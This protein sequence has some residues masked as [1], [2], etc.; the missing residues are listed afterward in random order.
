[1]R[2]TFDI[3]VKD[4][5][6]WVR[7]PSAM[8]ILLGMPAIL[9]LILGFALGGLTSGG[10]ARIPVAIVNLDSRPVALRADSA[11][12]LEDRL[13]GEKRI[14][15]LFQME[16][17]RDLAGV[18]ARVANGDLSAAL[19]IPHGFGSALADGRPVKLQVLTDPG[20]GLSAGIWESIVR[21]VATRYS[22]ASVI[23]RTAMEAA[24]NANSPA[25][26]SP[27]GASAIAGYA[28]SRGSADDALD[29]VKVTDTVAT[30]VSDLGAIDYYSLSMTAMF[31]MFG[32][33]FGAFSTIQER[34]EQT[35]ARM[36]ASPTARGSIVGGKMLGVFVMGMAQFA[37]LYAFTRF[38]LK[39]QWGAS[40]AATLTI[41]AAEMVAVT[42]LATLISSLARSE[43][44]AGGIG[45]LV[46]QIQALLGGAFFSVEIL[47]VWMQPVRYLSVVGWTM[48][49]W[50]A[51][52]TQGAG[53]AGVLGPTLALFAF[54]AV[55]FAFGVWRME[56]SR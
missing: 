49:G 3:A 36:L 31:L 38:V 2:R 5:L 50:R 8:G 46:V 42:G 45:P 40:P 13:T 43:R 12:E 6:V 16:R 47:P 54:G 52:Q 15:A 22:A 21:S 56:T 14:R 30:S 18:Q 28:V 27:G 51:I 25:L 4:L 24:K 37:V 34:R 1:M 9:I 11:A 20:S 17:S 33:M 10:E 44:A 39:V 41:A 29:G 19:V 35:M 7:D 23:V 26:A 53:V 32:S 55:F 48:D